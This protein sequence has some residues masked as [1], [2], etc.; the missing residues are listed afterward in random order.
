MPAPGMLSPNLASVLDHTSHVL[1]C[2][3]HAMVSGALDC[4]SGVALQ[5]AHR[6]VSKTLSPG[7]Q[8]AV[9][10][11]IQ[12]SGEGGEGMKETGGEGGLQLTRKASDTRLPRVVTRQGRREAVPC[13]GL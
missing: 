12:G 10:A 6:P 7:L 9:E 3:V 1:T 8:E 13:R 4:T 2:W 5:G 11:M